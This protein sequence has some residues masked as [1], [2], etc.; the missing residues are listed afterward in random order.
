MPKV[1]MLN[2]VMLSAIMPNVIMLNVIMLNVV[3]TS[4]VAPHQHRRNVG[5]S[6]T[7]QGI[8]KGK[9]PLYR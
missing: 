3:I 4:V 8:L 6:A 7:Q 9:V 2:I 1:I 5:A